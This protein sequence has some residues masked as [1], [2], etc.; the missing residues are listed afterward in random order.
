MEQSSKNQAALRG[1]AGEGPR[2]SH[3]N[4]GVTYFTFPLEVERLS[5]TLDI[6]NVVAS[7][8]VL[9]R[10]PVSPGEL[11]EVTGSVR[12]FNNRS[13]VGSRLVI[14]LFARTL[15]PAQGEHENHLELTGTLCKAPSL[16]T[17]PLG[18]EICDLLLAV[19]RPYGRADYLPCIAWGALA[20]A[21]GELQVGDR[22]HLT[23]RLQSRVYRKVLGT[24]E[25]ERTAYEVSVLT[26][27]RA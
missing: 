16:R 23:G 2:P 26:L 11:Y 21:C 7:Q 18:R 6:L 1:R 20:R 8:E 15:S 19:N 5:G 13:G 14:T 17:T 22:V 25:E 12:S 3:T 4:H 10:C 24:H 9:E 27:E